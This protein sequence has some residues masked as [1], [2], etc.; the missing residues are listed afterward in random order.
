V[1]IYVGESKHRFHIHKEL[2]CAKVPYFQKMFEGRFK[3]AVEQKAD[4]PDDNP[5]A[6]SLFVEW[7]YG[8][9]YTQIDIDK[10]TSNS[11]L[12]VDRIRLYAFAEKICLNSLMNYTI[13]TLMSNYKEHVCFPTAA[14]ATLAYEL[15]P[16]GSRLRRFMSN[17]LAQIIKVEFVD[18]KAWAPDEI[19]VAMMGSQNLTFDVLQLLH[20][21]DHKIMLVALYMEKCHFHTP[22]K[23]L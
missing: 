10:R 17:C 12:F 18:P 11:G 23:K 8:S 6:F 3:E 15:C 7:L 14:A 4:L 16:V 2:L 22:G 20:G 9:R 19:A 21:K 1:D 5:A 13:T